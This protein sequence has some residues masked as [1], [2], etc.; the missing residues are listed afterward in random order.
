MD[1]KTRAE[2]RGILIEHL[3]TQAILEELGPYFIL[4]MDEPTVPDVQ[5]EFGIEADF[6]DPDPKCGDEIEDYFID[7]LRT[8]G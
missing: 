2:V 7:R 8:L 4:P 6:A 3:F 5:Q 1:V